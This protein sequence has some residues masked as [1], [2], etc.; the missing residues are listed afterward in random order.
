MEVM[1]SCDRYMIMEYVSRQTKKFRL[2]EMYFLLKKIS[3]GTCN[4]EYVKL[5]LEWLADM[6]LVKKIMIKVKP[7][8][9]W[10]YYQA[11]YDY[12]FLQSR[13]K[14]SSERQC[15]EPVTYVC[16]GL[17]EKVRCR[18]AEIKEKINHATIHPSYKSPFVIAEIEFAVSISQGERER[19]KKKIAELD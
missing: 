1:I 15:A 13:I 7:G 17:P 19:L 9:K 12:E 18:C 6:G 10:L 14:N 8:Q 16:C 5:T 2:A 3:P 11:C 4:A